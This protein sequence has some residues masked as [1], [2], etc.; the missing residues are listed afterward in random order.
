MKTSKLR[1]DYHFHPN[2][3]KNNQRALKKCRYWWEKLKENN[4]QCLI[5][6]E[7]SYKNPRRAFELMDKARPKG[8]FCFPGMEYIT[9]EGID[10]IVFSDTPKIYGLDELKPFR[11]KYNDLVD[12]VLSKKNLFAFVT[13]PYILGTTSVIRNLNRKDYTKAVNLL[14]AVE[15]SNSVYD[16]LEIIMKK[17]PFNIIFKQKLE[18]IKKTRDLPK[19]DYPKDIKFL[20]A[21][22]DAT[23]TQELGNCFEIDLPKKEVPSNI[24]QYVAKNKGKGRVSVKEKKLNLLLLLQTASTVFNEFLIKVI[25]RIKGV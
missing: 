4:I 9:K 7:H 15:I 8:F 13:H 11:L 1:I 14:G 6:T 3:P 2:L 19:S 5:I 18:N 10:I 17:I 22:S 16:N 23:Y 21:G 25:L 20:A 24:F 12:F